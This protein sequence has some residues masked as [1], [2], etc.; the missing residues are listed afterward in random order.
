MNNQSS[1]RFYKDKP[2][3]MDM[4]D[5]MMIKMILWMDT[6]QVRLLPTPAAG[7]AATIS[8]PL[9]CWALHG[10]GY[11]GVGDPNP[12]QHSHYSD[13]PLSIHIP[14]L[15][16]FQRSVAPA[17]EDMFR[18]GVEMCRTTYMDVCDDADYSQMLK[19]YSKEA[20][21]A[22]V[23]AITSAGQLSLARGGSMMLPRRHNKSRLGVFL[24]GWVTGSVEKEGGG[25]GVEPGGAG[26]MGSL[27]LPWPDR[28]YVGHGRPRGNGREC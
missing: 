1:D 5:D 8:Q 22:G 20:E 19:G 23:S 6:G 4:I 28:L 9:N 2:M 11:P 25:V 13:D 18:G 10:A 17:A 14:L 24:W 12:A 7:S 27:R 3:R 16:V 21:E 26:V 15:L